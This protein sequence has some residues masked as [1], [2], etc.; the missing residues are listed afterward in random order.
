MSRF[1]ARA[2]E[3]D[4]REKIARERERAK[5]A[6]SA[7]ELKRLI[8]DAEHRAEEAEAR[9]AF[10][11]AT[12]F[13]PRAATRI[14]APKKKGALPAAAYFAEASDWHVGERVRPSEVGYRN[15]YKPEIAAERARQYFRSN[16]LLLNAARAAWA[17]DTYVQWLGGDFITGWIH[18]EYES[19]N[20]LAPQEEAGLAFDLLEDGLLFL[21]AESDCG[22][23]LVPTSNGNHGRGS[24]KPRAAGAFRNSYE[25]M[26]Y[27]QLARRFKHEP[28]I[29]FQISQGYYNDINV[30]GRRVRASHGDGIKYGGGVGGLTVPFYRRIGRDAQS[31]GDVLVYMQ[32]HFH[33]WQFARKLAQNGSLIGWNAYAERGGFEFEAPMQVSFVVDERYGLVSNANPVLVDKPRRGVRR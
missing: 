21:L 24:K 8:R 18:E 4:A 16:L 25:F 28:R 7:A 26:L 31:V 23:I 6:A 27:N 12:E 11:D 9:A 13:S 5:V 14:R 22:T 17:I 2:P 15:E 33:Q 32:G 20:Y 19:E 1:K 30:Y 3:A 10:L 29:K